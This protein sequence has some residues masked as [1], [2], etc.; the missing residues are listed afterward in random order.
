MNIKGVQTNTGKTHFKKGCISLMLGKHHTKETKEKIRL[1]NLGKPAWNKGKRGLYKP[2]E[3]IKKRISLKLIGKK[4][5]KETRE[6]ISLANKGRTSQNK[7]ISMTEEQKK[8]IKKALIDRWNKIGRK[9]KNKNRH[10]ALGYETWRNAVFSRDNWT[11]IWCKK[12]GGR[13]QAHHIKSWVNY[14]ELRY[15]LD[16]GVILCIKCH[17]NATIEQRKQEKLL[18]DK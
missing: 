16:N 3:E 10:H 11:C 12:R 4:V 9:I 18:F 8:K 5:S 1:K 2:S 7:G 15:I 13:L 14:P 6:K 17:K